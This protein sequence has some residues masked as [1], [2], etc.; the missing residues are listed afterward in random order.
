MHFRSQKLLGHVARFPTMAIKDFLLAG[1]ILSAQLSE[2]AVIGPS[3]NLFR[4][5]GVIA[6]APS[7]VEQALAPSALTK[8]DGLRGK[9]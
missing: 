3:L 7:R 8:R 9:G 4:G 2:A 1:L 6:N 5:T